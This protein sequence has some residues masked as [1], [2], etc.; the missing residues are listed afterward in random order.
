MRNIGLE[1]KLRCPCIYCLNDKIRTIHVVRIHL[2]QRGISLSYKTWV[3]HGELDPVAQSLIPNEGH[4]DIYSEIVGEDQ[5]DGDDLPTM[6]EE[7]CRGFAMDDEGDEL[8][9]TSKS[10]DGRNLD[11]LFEDAQRKLYTDCTRLTVLSFVIKMFHIKVYNKWS[12]N[13]FDMQT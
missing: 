1:D 5:D 10:V 6:L 3:H 4:H 9:A 11:K 13:S 12:N 7:V 8:P 2:I